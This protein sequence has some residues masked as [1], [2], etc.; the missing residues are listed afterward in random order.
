[1]SHID[2]RVLEE[3]V[4]LLTINRPDKKNALDDAAVLELSLALESDSVQGLSAVI[5]N[6]TGDHFCAGVDLGEIGSVR[7]RPVRPAGPRLFAAFRECGPVVIGA[8]QGYALGLGCGL[9]V[10]CDL[11]VAA[12]SSQFGYPAI[13]HGLVNGVTM[14]GLKET[15]GSKA[16]M[17]LLVTGRRIDA[18]EARAMGMINH[19]VPDTELL[20]RA[21]EL[22]RVVASHSTFAVQTTKQFFHEATDLSFAA[23]TLAG[24][25]VVQLVRRAD[26]PEQAVKTPSGK[27]PRP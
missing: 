4:G 12:E 3:S 16:A 25:R 5:L 14:V 2:F 6:A 26:A 22:A 13:R 18:H 1:M 24:E 21:V 23:A 10:A 27:E 8:V 17:E 19:V 11:V 15:V 9:A 20:D 7:P